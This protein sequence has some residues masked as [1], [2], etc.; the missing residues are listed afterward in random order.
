MIKITL[1]TNTKRD[2]FMVSP[3]TKV[4][5]F[6]AEHKVPFESETTRLDGAVLDVAGMNK[7]FTDHGIEDECSISVVTKTNNR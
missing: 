7:S 6:L 2:T 4:K 1:L 5:A 3:D